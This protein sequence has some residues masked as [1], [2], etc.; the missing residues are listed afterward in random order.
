VREYLPKITTERSIENR[1]KKKL[2]LAGVVFLVSSW[3]LIAQNAPPAP[4]QQ[5]QP[6]APPKASIEGTVTRSGS[7][8]PLKGVQ[9]TIQRADTAAVGGRAGNR[10]QAGASAAG[11][12][13]LGDL[14]AAFTG[15]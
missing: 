3:V 2:L 5:G 13:A 8:L 10:G 14:I 6:V 12:G 4:S 9:I 1:M 15:G 11:L 7:G